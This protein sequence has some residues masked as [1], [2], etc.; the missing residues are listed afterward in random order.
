MTKL[1]ARRKPKPMGLSEPN[2][3]RCPGHLKWI[4]GFDCSAS[5]WLCKSAIEAAHVRTGTDGGT[6]MKP[7]DCWT[8]PL[9]RYH[10]AEQH[11]LGEWLFEKKYDIN[12]K[13]IAE[14]LWA[15]SPHGKKWRSEHE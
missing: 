12:M 13:R 9:C 7:S 8:I 2:V 11:D 1:P 5:N 10:H 4:R 14:Q 6:G 15:L 3:I